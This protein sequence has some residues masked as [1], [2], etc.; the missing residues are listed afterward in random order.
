MRSATGVDLDP[1]GRLALHELRWPAADHE[2]GHDAQ[3]LPL[4]VIRLGREDL[5]I[6]LSYLRA[7]EITSRYMA[8]SLAIRALMPLPPVSLPWPL[9]GTARAYGT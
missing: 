9:G 4:Q 3:E 7:A 6:G 1:S 2:L 8:G 5:D